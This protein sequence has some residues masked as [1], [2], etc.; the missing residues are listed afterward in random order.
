MN[1]DISVNIYV[2]ENII[3]RVFTY[4][5]WGFNKAMKITFVVIEGKESGTS[6]VYYEGTIFVF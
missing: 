2:A 6:A 1:G 5:Q 3:Q 4:V